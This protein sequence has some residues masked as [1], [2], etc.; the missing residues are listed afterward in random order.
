MVDT[1][2][3]IVAGV[4]VSAVMLFSVWQAMKSGIGGGTGRPGN[5]GP[6]LFG[7]SALSLYVAYKYVTM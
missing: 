2:K 5:N 4:A 3:V 1:G 6:M 7:V